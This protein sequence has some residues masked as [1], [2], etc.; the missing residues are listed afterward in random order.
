MSSQSV[1]CFGGGV[2]AGEPTFSLPLFHPLTACPFLFGA[3][4]TPPNTG[5][6]FWIV[7]LASIACGLACGRRSRSCLHPSLAWWLSYLSSSPVLGEV[8]LGGGVRACRPTF[9]LP[10][11]HPL[12]ARPFLFGAAVTPPNTGGEFWIVL[13]ASVAC[14]VAELFKLLPCL[15]GVAR[16]RGRLTKCQSVPKRGEHSALCDGD[17]KGPFRGR[18][19]VVSFCRRVCVHQRS[20]SCNTTLHELMR[21]LALSQLA[22]SSRK[23]VKA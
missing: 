11:S 3:A 7:L 22:S 2:R 13:L 17:P 20:T 8:P 14:M 19:E 23:K 12:T 18:G 5:G 16:P 10:L 21:M 15:R 1:F 9:S 6:E 4:V